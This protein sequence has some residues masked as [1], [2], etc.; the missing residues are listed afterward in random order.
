MEYMNF[1]KVVKQM[2]WAM[3]VIG[4]LSGAGTTAGIFA[5]L[6]TKQKT[7]N[8][9]TEQVKLQQKLTDYDLVKPVCTPE[10]IKSSV[11]GS[12][13]C[14][15]LFCRMQQR[16]IDSKTSQVDCSNIGNMLNKSSLYRF[17]QTRAKNDKD[18]FKACIELYDRRL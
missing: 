5:A 16:G 18:V 9:A 12:L 8:T 1:S 17:C 3:F 11:D 7:T 6:K 14:R 2:T 15:E 13:L 10:F 4:L